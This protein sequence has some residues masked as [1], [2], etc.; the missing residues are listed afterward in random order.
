MPVRV[1]AILVVRPDGRT[2]ATAR[3]SRT[4]EALAAQ[5]R[6]VDALTIVLCGHDASLSERAA[7]APAE[8]VVQLPGSTPYARAVK[9][10]SL[11]VEPD[12]A[13]WLLAQDTVPGPE[14]LAQLAGALELSPTVAM[15]APK[16][17]RAGT[18]DAIVSLGETMTGSG[19]TVELA[20]GELDQGQHDDA[21]DVLGADVRG[22]LVR[23]DA[24]KSLE[25]LDTALAGADEGLDLGIRARLAGGRVSVVP[26]AR[27]TVWGDG[28]AGTPDPS[29][30]GRIRRRAFATRTAQLHRRM[31]Y[32]SLIALPVLWLAI[33]PA[34]IARTAGHLVLKRPALIAPE[35]AAAV[36]VAVRWGAIFRSRRRIA[37]TRTTSWRM[38]APLRTT[39]AQLRR[40]LDSDGG[41]DPVRSELRFFSG[42]GAWIV[43]AALAVSIA[44]FPALLAWR[45][46]GGGAILPL[47]ESVQR[48]WSDAAYGARPTGL[49]AVGP[50]DPFAAVVAVL[51]SL[52]PWWPST[53]LVVLWILAL[54]LA[55]L[56]GWF[57]ATRLT[58]RSG[59]RIVGGVVWALAPTFL[60]ALTDARPAAV[61]AHLLLPWLFYTASAA[62]RSWGA[63]GA[64]SLVLVAVVACAPQLAPALAVLWV[65]AIVITAATRHG[66]GVPRLIW[67]V[68]PTVVVF[69]PLVFAQL[70]AR[71][72]WGLLGDPGA[73]WSGPTVP[74]D[75]WG[76]FLL[77]AGFP[78]EDV[79]G[80]AG[81]VGHGA[82]WATLLV[83]P[84]V[85]VA[86]AAPLTRRWLSGYV[87]LAVALAGIGTAFAV[88]GIS[89]STT[90]AQ[91]VAIW[92]GP[93]LSLAWLGLAGAALT[94]L[95]AGIVRTPAFVRPLAASLVV[96]ALVALSVPALTATARQSAQI[97]QGA[98]ST[99]PAYVAAVGRD[100]PRVGTL[101]VTPLSGDT[102]SS[103]VVWGATETLGGTSTVQTTRT[104][105]SAS[106]PLLARLTADLIASTD[107]GAVAGL[108][109]QG[110]GFVLLADPPAGA[111]DAARALLLSAGTRID[112]RDTL[113]SIGAT[114]TGELW[115]LA[116]A[117][118]ERAGAD[119]DQQALTRSVLV[120][121]LIVLAVA[122]LL[123]VPTPASRREALRRSRIV[124]DRGR[125]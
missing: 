124:G 84:L 123:S 116:S 33:L 15:V 99:L 88:A 109:E 94:T 72:P 104:S 10:A 7:S 46:L 32:A 1:H 110:I 34:A 42:G 19:R 122:L 62:H 2:P 82:M 75:A 64:A 78:T 22:L 81:L 118:A 23:G 92:P 80:W 96:I 98:D 89:V 58:D 107:G 24:W 47:G 36:V 16:L 63:A 18:T 20:E 45:S 44:A 79:A 43:L 9:L 100:D 6:A 95:D 4:L 11:R 85:V 21:A 55:V 106:D 41:V 115:Q 119:R 77:T 48:L 103:R 102:V 12:A 91:S 114:G 40:R 105:P 68:L 60:T 25:G 35:F 5:S 53:A 59:L 97:A 50:A 61:I 57:A 67:T 26:A 71:N 54:P 73:V 29:D 112:Q 87:L 8:G 69:A 125:A 74:A 70:T 83:V 39:R 14:A 121:Q 27:V 37:R 111:S 93:A 117:P 51:G 17:L 49:D 113:V 56:G 108:A 38:L 52:T 3:L 65:I 120:L 101:V 66:R 31:A 76:R 13:I 86:L 28:V 90:L 30:A